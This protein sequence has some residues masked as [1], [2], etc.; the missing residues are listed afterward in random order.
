MFFPEHFKNFLEF[1][2]F[3]K[4]IFAIIFFL[5]EFF[6]IKIQKIEKGP[7]QNETM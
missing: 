2:L 6:F 1:F 4:I 3:V 5:Q 7:V